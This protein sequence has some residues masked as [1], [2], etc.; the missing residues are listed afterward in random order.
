MTLLLLAC[1]APDHPARPEL[2]DPAVLDDEAAP[3][4]GSEDSDPPGDSDPDDSD[5]DDG[6]PP[7]EEVDPTQPG[8]Y[9]VSTS[10]RSFTTSCSMSAT[11]FEPAGGSER[12]VV[13][14]HGF[15][16]SSANMAG[17]AEHWASHG[18]TVVTPEL[19]HAS[20]W[21]TDHVQNG[22]DLADLAASLGADEVF[23]AGHSAGGLAALLAVEQSALA[24]GWLGLDPVDSEGLGAAATPAVP[25]T[26]VVGAASDCNA[27]AS[28]LD[29]PG[30][31]SQLS[32]ADH[33]DFESPTDWM[34]TTFCPDAGGD[35]HETILALSTEAVLR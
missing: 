15:A 35:V 26:V 2:H 34:C 6:D 3:D 16:R 13:L 32:G 9:E 22:E 30:E 25:A 17:W 10:S 18:V 5:P 21:D 12:V 29:F 14:A 7:E 24:V 8:P 31:V 4:S 11:V 20:M 1:A 19:C 23:F 27:S 28:G 33:C